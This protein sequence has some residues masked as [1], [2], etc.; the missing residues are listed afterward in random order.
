MKI[1]LID[2]SA[3][4]LP[5]RKALLCGAG[6]EVQTAGATDRALANSANTPPTALD[7]VITVHILFCASGS[8][9]VRQLRA[10]EPSIPEIV[11][12]GGAACSRRVQGPECIFP[13]ETL[14]GTLLVAFAQELASHEQ[15]GCG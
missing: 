3:L 10:I 13:L 11:N 4:Q 12:S 2:N 9:F 1:L 7:F 14:P 5:V 15:R 8:V 6:F